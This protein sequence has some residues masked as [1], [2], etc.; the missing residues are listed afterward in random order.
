MLFL[1]MAWEDQPRRSDIECLSWNDLIRFMETLL[2]P[3]YEDITF[4]FKMKLNFFYT[5]LVYK[6]IQIYD[7]IEMFSAQTFILL[8]FEM[9]FSVP[10]QSPTSSV[11][12]TL[13]FSPLVSTLL[14]K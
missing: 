1:L 8:H 9:L 14:L 3:F 4:R 11:P 13:T 2:P 6:I 7:A 5:V 10:S 12:L